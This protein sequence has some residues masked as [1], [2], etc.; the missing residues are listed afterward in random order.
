MS[1]LFTEARSG[2]ELA[3]KPS[4][5][6]DRGAETQA[7][8]RDKF[9]RKVAEMCG[10]VERAAVHRLA[11]LPHNRRRAALAEL[12]GQHAERGLMDFLAA[13]IDDDLIDDLATTLSGGG[14]RGEAEGLLSELWTRLLGMISPQARDVLYA[15]HQLRLVLEAK[16]QETSRDGIGAHSRPY[17][18]AL[19]NARAVLAATERFRD[20]Q[21]RGTEE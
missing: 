7:M 13:L 3:E 15:H 16:E 5:R 17:E 8:K 6:A 9:L 19:D 10:P 12:S 11:Q 2:T 21:T 4:R 1:L 18:S 20:N 14:T